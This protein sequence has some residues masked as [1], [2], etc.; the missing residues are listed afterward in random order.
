[1]KMLLAILFV[2][3]TCSVVVAK[4]QVSLQN[5]TG[6]EIGSRTSPLYT[7]SGNS[8]VSQVIHTGDKQIAAV[9]SIIVD[10]SVYY[11]GVTVGDQISLYNVA[12]QVGSPSDTNKVLQFYAPTA[13]GY[14]KLVDNGFTCDT[15]IY[16]DS[17]ITTGAMGLQLQSF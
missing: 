17:T 1:M 16:M 15:G 7:S 11:K 4:D 14:T 2:F 6:T 10:A 5:G 9:S 12:S 3:F 13:N 8:S